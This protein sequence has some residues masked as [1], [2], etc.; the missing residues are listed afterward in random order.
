MSFLSFS[1]RLS[2]E[3][4]GRDLSSRPVIKR[5]FYSSI[6]PRKRFSDDVSEFPV[7]KT[8]Y[9]VQFK[10]LDYSGSCLTIHRVILW[11]LK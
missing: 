2:A 9:L 7:F 11:T 5:G 4:K 10:I 3:S 6:H 8:F 1:Q